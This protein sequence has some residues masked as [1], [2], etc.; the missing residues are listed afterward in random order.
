V[1]RTNPSAYCQKFALW[2]IVEA[3]RNFF[4]LEL[5][6]DLNFV[7]FLDEVPLI[8]YAILTRDDDGVGERTD[9]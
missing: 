8:Q 6:F 7:G 3:S 5:P 9:G 1:D 4:G 2:T